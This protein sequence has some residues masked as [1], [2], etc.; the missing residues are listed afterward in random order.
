MDGR[1]VTDD[2]RAKAEAYVADFERRLGLAQKSD[3]VKILG[4]KAGN[5]FTALREKGFHD[6]FFRAYHSL[7]VAFYGRLVAEWGPPFNRPDAY[8]PSQL[9]HFED[10]ERPKE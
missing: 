4:E 2:V 9:Y 3:E 7:Q 6:L 8:G 5:V 1:D 10:P